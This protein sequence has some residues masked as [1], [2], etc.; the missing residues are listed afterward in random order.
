MSTL[1][2]TRMSSKGQVVIPESV[3]D[4]LGLTAG[5][6]FLVVGEGDVVVLKSLSAPSMREFDALVGRA[7]QQ[8]RASG[9]RPAD[10]RKAVERVRAR[11]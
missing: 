3:R 8:A 2:T 9:L 10:V 11:R 5:A 1:T 6:E 7:R 4:R